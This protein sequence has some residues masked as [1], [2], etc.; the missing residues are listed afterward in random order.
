MS[1][2]AWA[3]I[4]GFGLWVAIYW[5]LP[6]SAKSYIWAHELTHAIWA[7]LSGARVGKIKIGEN[8]G[9]VMLSRT[10]A[11]IGLAPYFFPFYALIAILVWWILCFF[12]DPGPWRALWMFVVGIAWGHH[13]TYTIASLAIRQPDIVDN[14]HLFSYALIYLFNLFGICLW[15]VATTPATFAEFLPILGGRTIDAYLWTFDAIATAFAWL[16][17]SVRALAR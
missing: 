9:Y 13:V 2:E 11:I 7:L 10:N 5:F 8:G 16:Y 17:K 12:V 6:I 15:V 4:C 1:L 3:L 14:G